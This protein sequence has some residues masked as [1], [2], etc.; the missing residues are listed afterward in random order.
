MNLPFTVEQFLEVFK[1][2]NLAVWPLQILFYLLAMVVVFLSFKKFSYADQLVSAILALFWVWMGIAYHFAYFTTINKAAYIFG[3]LFILQGIL[4]LI[5]GVFKNRSSFQFQPD[6]YG[7]TG[8]LLILYALIGYPILSSSFGHIFPYTPS[9]GLP[10]PTTIFTLGLLL[11]N[12]SKTSLAILIIPVLWS[13]IGFTA[14]FSLGIYE[15][16]GLLIAAVLVCIMLL[17]K[18]KNH[19]HNMTSHST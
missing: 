11:W 8:A 3:G 19:L 16:T 7:F 9:F 4:F 17:L 18:R 5:Y 1:N 12:R 6:T 13:A 15:D 10:C 14:A 2:Y